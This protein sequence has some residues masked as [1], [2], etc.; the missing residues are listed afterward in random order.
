MTVASVV[1]MPWI[2]F[3]AITLPPKYVTSRWGATWVGFDVALLSSLAA[4]AWFAWRRYQAL[5]VSA[6]V[7]STL[8]VTDAWFDIM[9]SS[10]R[11][12]LAISIATAVLVELPLAVLLFSVAYRLLQLAF[13]RARTV[14]GVPGTDGALWN[15]PLLGVPQRGPKGEA[16][17][18]S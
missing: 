6:L 2:V 8:L 13:R 5:V 3:L 12:D 17:P 10:S 4:T 1:L 16:A 9:T 7:A 14:V 11:T 18:L 15:D